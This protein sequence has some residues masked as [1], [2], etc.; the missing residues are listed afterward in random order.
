M[1]KRRERGEALRRLVMWVSP[2]LC[3][4]AM[5]PAS[6]EVTGFG[7][8]EWLGDGIGTHGVF[9]GSA[10]LGIGPGLHVL[11][12]FSY[13]PIASYTA[14]QLGITLPSGV[15]SASASAH[16][17]NGG[18]GVDLT[19]RSE[20][21]KVR[22]YVIGVLGAGIFKVS[23]NA[24]GSGVSANV[25]LSQNTFYSGGGGGARIYVGP[26]WGFKP[27][28]RFQHYYS[29]GGSVNAVLFTGG[30]FFQFGK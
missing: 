11:G 3:A 23:G 14:A 9:G 20:G 16:L 26:R 2:L 4:P 5:W 22:P 25:S 21:A 6:A 13:V 1:L 28:F 18:G 24:S 7:G 29:S 15:N 30:V 17:L 8:G 19:F 12:E 10:D 27:E